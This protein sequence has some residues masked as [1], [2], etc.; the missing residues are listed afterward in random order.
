MDTFPCVSAGLQGASSA[1]SKAMEGTSQ[2]L[3]HLSGHCQALDQQLGHLAVEVLGPGAAES[4]AA[5]G[6]TAL[7]SLTGHGYATSSPGVRGCHGDD[8]SSS[9]QGQACAQFGASSRDHGWGVAVGDVDGLENGEL[10]WECERQGSAGTGSFG[11]EGGIGTEHRSKH[12]RQD[13]SSRRGP[14]GLTNSNGRGSLGWAGSWRG[15]SEGLWGAGEG[16]QQVMPVATRLARLE[17][18]W[19][20]VSSGLTSK[21]DAGEVGRAGAGGEGGGGAT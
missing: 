5:T 13:R 10:L 12:T 19:H 17:A 16:H 14:P 7:R 18:V 8:P 2:R 20:E 9:G 15:R 6:A 21:G 1:T 11:S 3:Q 4:L